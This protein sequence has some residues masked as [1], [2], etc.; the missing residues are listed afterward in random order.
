M[1]SRNTVTEKS[2][3]SAH[4]ENYNVTWHFVREHFIHG[5]VS[6]KILQEKYIE[7]CAMLNKSESGPKFLFL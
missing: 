2:L 7:K 6:I 4:M 3:F 1:L 5:E